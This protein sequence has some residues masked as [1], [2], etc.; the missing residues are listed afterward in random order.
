[1]YSRVPMYQRNIVEFQ[2]TTQQHVAGNSS[3]YRDVTKKKIIELIDDRW[4][5]HDRPRMCPIYLLLSESHRGATG[6][7]WEPR[8]I[9]EKVFGFWSLGRE[10][11]AAVWRHNYGQCYLPSSRGTDKDRGM[12]REKLEHLG[13]E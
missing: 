2:C 4:K 11:D 5:G 1:M 9:N 13:E 7:G 10:A 12:Y 8:I 6:R 3:M